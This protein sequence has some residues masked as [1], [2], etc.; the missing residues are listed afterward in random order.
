MAIYPGKNKVL[1]FTLCFIIYVLIPCVLAQEPGAM[2]KA[3]IIIAAGDFRDEEFLEPKEILEKNGVKT[4]VASTI[5]TPVKGVLG[6][7]VSPDI[8]VKD[9]NIKDF[10][11]I[12]FVGGIGASQYWDDPL[13]HGLARK[14]A[15]QNR[16]VAAICIAP[17]TLARAGILKGKEATV[18][19]YEA[20]EL[21]AG[22]AN[23]TARPVEKDGNIITASGPAS[24]REFGQQIIE[25]LGR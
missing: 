3:V 23:Y 15:A 16:I 17:V 1:V 18:F 10:D 13:A 5:L 6:A 7:E 20:K 19:T 25:A 12:I 11:A 2:K 4:T 22:G 14:A 21:R 9:I 24:A 8:L